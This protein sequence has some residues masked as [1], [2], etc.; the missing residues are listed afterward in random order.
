MIARISITFGEHINTESISS[1]LSALQ[2]TGNVSEGDNARAY[3]VEVRRAS[4][5]TYLQEQLMKWERYGFL[6]YK[7][8]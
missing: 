3:A 2:A 1:M 4:S 6:K 5:M 8:E 7:I